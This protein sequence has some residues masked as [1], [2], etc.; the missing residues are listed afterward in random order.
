MRVKELLRGLLFLSFPSFIHAFYK[1]L[2]D[3]YPALANLSSKPPTNLSP[4]LGGRSGS[5][6]CKLA[7]N[8]S[9][10]IENGKLAFVPG[11]TFIRG[12]IQALEKFGNPCTRSYTPGN[13]LDQPQVMVNYDW[14][15]SNCPG[16]GLTQSTDLNV[17]ARPLI[18][19]IAPSAVFSVNIPRRRKIQ[20]PSWLLSR[21][22]GSITSVLAILIKVPLASFIVTFDAILWLLVVFTLSGPM[23]L[24]GLYEAMLDVR[25]LRYLD[26]HVNINSMSV[27][28]RAHLLLVVLLGNLDIQSAW[29]DSERLVG[30][31]ENESPRGKSPGLSTNG[32]PLISHTT[33]HSIHRLD[34]SS[35]GTGTLDSSHQILTTTQL[36]SDHVVNSVKSKMRGMMESQTGFGTAVG[37]AIVFYS[38]AFI[39]AMV[40]AKSLYGSRLVPVHSFW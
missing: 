18:S 4:H 35:I 1:T 17:W 33:T 20:V 16:W 9:I 30:P 31:L 40:E 38:A 3:V 29:G 36:P 13:T 27:R 11:Q 14:C 6:C 21:N 34:N 5:W 32:Q 10:Q 24:S 7:M 39:Y 22:V 37:A 2:G 12:D 25:I 28:Q 15:S 23:I 19:F 26:Y 8:Q